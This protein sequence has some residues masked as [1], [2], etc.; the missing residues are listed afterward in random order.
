MIYFLSIWNTYKS[1]RFIICLSS[2]I[3]RKGKLFMKKMYMIPL[4]VLVVLAAIVGISWVSAYNGEIKK[5]NLIENKRGDVHAALGARYDK[6][7]ALIDAI[8]GANQTVTEYLN[9]IKEGRE[10]FAEALDNGDFASADEA[11]DVIDSTFVT[12][13]SYMEQNPE[14]YNT[15]SLYAGF[16]GE[17]SAS[18]NAVLTAIEDF[19]KTV[20]EYN[21]H[22]QTFPNVLFL[23]DK[24]PQQSY[25]VSNYN[26][27]LPT[28][29]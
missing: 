18:T 24:T 11:A 3:E 28:F 6:V 16:A 5:N 7:A 26:A 8:Q 29:N 25:S 22:I 1:F 2:Y 9:I 10:A 20:R 19:N 4:L 23:G 14:S 12:L 15:V 21:D 27:S 17:F 13:L